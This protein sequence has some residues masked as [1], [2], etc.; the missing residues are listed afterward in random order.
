M[1][2]LFRSARATGLLALLIV[3]LSACDAAAGDPG[4]DPPDPPVGADA[5]DGIYMR[6]KQNG[7]SGTFDWEYLTFFRDGRVMVHMPEEGLERF[8]RDDWDRACAHTFCGTYT[9]AGG[10]VTVR[11]DDG[12]EL[13]FDVEA[14]GALQRRGA[15]QSYRPTPPLDGLR[16]DGVYAQIDEVNDIELAWARFTADGRFE[17][18]NLMAHT[19]WVHFAP[20]GEEREALE[21]GSGTYTI[22][23]NALEL[24]YDGGPTAYFTIVVPPGNASNPGSSTLYVNNSQIP[25]L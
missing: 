19:Q 8:D 5:L 18:R 22:R 11:W 23:R 17:E 6:Y 3:S 16:L 2:T 12:D 13:V 21:G 15:A 9:R 7:I 25:R 4:D 1:H 14:G 10:V 24:R 20:P